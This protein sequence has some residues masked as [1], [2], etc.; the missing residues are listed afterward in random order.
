MTAENPYF[1]IFKAIDNFFTNHIID[2]NPDRA[3]NSNIKARRWVYPSYPEK[4]DERFPRVAI[5]FGT[6]TFSNTGADNFVQDV[7]ENGRVVQT[8]NGQILTVPVMIAIFVKRDQ[9]YQVAYSDGTIHP[10]QNEKQ[11]DYLAGQVAQKLNFYYDEFSRVGIT[12]ENSA[13]VVPSYQDDD[14]TFVS[15][16]EVKM[17]II[18][19]S[20]IQ[21]SESDIIRI[22]NTTYGVVQ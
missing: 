19:D 7:I 15:E 8:I 9:K 18:A 6:G 4:N 16:V 17:S 10:V 1:S 5:K 21:Y 20:I 13:T 12:I 2:I 11:C 3:N 14:E 22:I